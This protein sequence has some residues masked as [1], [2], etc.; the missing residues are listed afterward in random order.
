[1]DYNT[2][3]DSVPRQLIWYKDCTE[4]LTESDFD[5]GESCV[6][7]AAIGSYREMGTDEDN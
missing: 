5:I 7:K 1:M 6:I 4:P 2:T 3:W